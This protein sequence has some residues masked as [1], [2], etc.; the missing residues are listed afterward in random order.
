MSMSGKK[1]IVIGNGMAAIRFLEQLFEDDAS[2]YCVTV[3]G[4]EPHAGYNRI[5]LSPLLSGEQTLEDVI[6]HPRSW[7][8]DRNIELITNTRIDKIDSVNKC[9]TDHNSDIYHY[10]QL[11]IATGSRPFVPDLP[12]TDLDG[13]FTYR[14]IDDVDAMLA[15]GSHGKRA[16]VIGGGL[17]GLEV[18]YGLKTRSMNVSVCHRHS[19][20]MERQL[21]DTASRHLASILIQKDIEIL[22]EANTLKL[23]GDDRVQ[24]VVLDDGRQLPADIV[25]FAVGIVPDIAL[26]KAAGID[27]ERGI[28]VDEK[29]QTSVHDIFAIGECV[30][31]NGITYGLVAPLYEQAAVLASYLNGD[32]KASY[33]GSINATGLKVTG[34]N[35]YSA[36]QF[37][38]DESCKTMQL[39]DA[40]NRLYRKLVFKNSRL[41]GVLLFGDIRGSNWFQELIESGQQIDNIDPL[42]IFGEPE[43]LLP[44]SHEDD[45]TL[46]EANYA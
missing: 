30:Q 5:L 11:I 14:T 26:A 40:A 1:I 25:V 12:G 43:L 39:S 9:I 36:G 22:T 10:D 15:A 33:Q 38:E 8:Q 2:T 34:V 13:V 44:P 41:I 7:Y 18:A 37:N 16:V 3:F 17:L 45:M 19:T 24:S 4:Q 20:L 32:K 27:C 42:M 21:D 35:L 46:P 28:L 29:M 31:H 23:E 6:T